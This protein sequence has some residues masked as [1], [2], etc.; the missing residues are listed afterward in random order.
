VVGVVEDDA[1]MRQAIRR[2]LEA[3][4]FATEVFG[5]AEAFLASGAATRVACLV[6]DIHL[7]GMSGIE[8]RQE[9]ASRGEGVATIFITAH[10][11]TRLRS[12]AAQWAHDYL[13]KPFL[14]ETLIRAV[15]RSIGT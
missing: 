13:V 4:G 6:L 9:L 5:S 3:E 8:L 2:V 15:A 10:D 12:A 14:G 11:D 1:A 7:P